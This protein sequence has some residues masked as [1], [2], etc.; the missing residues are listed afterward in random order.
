MS[1]KTYTIPSFTGLDQA[2]DENSLSPRFSPDAANMDT[3]GGRLSVAD[4]FSKYSAA[5]LPGSG[6][7]RLLTSWRGGSGEIPVAVAGGDVYA[8]IRGEWVLKYSYESPYSTNYDS[9]MV[10]IGSTDYLVI[11]DGLHR[12][13][14]F[15]GETCSLFGSSEQSS[16]AVCSYLAVY[17]GRLFAAG[18]SANPDRIYYSCLPGSGRTVEDWGYV[19]ASPAV[20]GGHAEVGSLGGDPIVAVKAMSNQ[21]LIFKR[22]SLYRLIGD[23][24]SNFTIEHI[25]ASVPTT[26][27]QAIAIHGDTAYFVTRRGLYF[28]NGVTARPCPD[29]RMIKTLTERASASASCAVIAED[30]LY[31]TLQRMLETLLVV[32][33]LQERKYM[34][35]KGISVH[36]MAALD[37]RPVFMNEN[38]LLF[39]LGVGAGYDGEPISAYWTTP[40]TD[41]EDK[42]CIKSPRLLLLRGSGRL[43]VEVELDGRIEKHVVTLPDS[44]SEVAEVPLFSSGRTLRL[45]FSNIDGGR[46][47]LEGGVEVELGM[48][49]RTE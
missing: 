19:Q 29:M 1:I 36:D 11:A 34:L 10:R 40:L 16:D 26:R 24:P 20:E 32:Y 30:K 9:C 37:G 48:R 46:F 47:T 8:L 42:A 5:V 4:G 13:I 45:R 17:R 21:L 27:Q 7:L 35:R 33:D 12:M 38:R 22:N 15:D 43:A 25:D 18:E 2:G 41:L 6:R 23:R 14:K 28:F 44:R 39:S 49:R 31:F 3:D